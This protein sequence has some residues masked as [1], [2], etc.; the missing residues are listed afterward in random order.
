[1][2]SFF[3]SIVR[4]PKLY[5]N[6]VEDQYMSVFAIA[7]PYT[8]PFKFSHY[9]VSLAHHVIGVWFIRCRLP[10]RKGFVKYIQRGLKS[11]VLQLFEENSLRHLSTHNQD[12]S[13]RGRTGSLNEGRRRRRYVSGKEG[14]RNDGHIPMDEKMSQ[15][16]K[17]LTET[18]LDMMA[19]YSFGNFNALPKRSP[20]AQFLL[21]DG[22]QGMWVVGNKVITVTTSGGGTKSSSSGLC[23]NCLTALQV[24]SQGQE[25][26]SVPGSSSS[27]SPYAVSSS[28]SPGSRQGE[29]RRHRSMASLST[30]SQSQAMKIEVKDGP[31]G[32][33]SRDDSTLPSEPSHDIF[34]H[35]DVAVQTGSS[36]SKEG[37]DPIL[38]ESSQRHADKTQRAF[39]AAQCSCWCTSWAE[40][41]I[42]GASG[43]V[44]WMMRIENEASGYVFDVDPS[45]PD[46]TQLLAPFRCKT[47]DSDS[48]GKIDSGSLCE[49]E[50]ETLHSQ[51]FSAAE[52]ALLQEEHGSPEGQPSHEHSEAREE[53]GSDEDKKMSESPTHLRRISSSPSS[54]GSGQDPDRP[55]LQEAALA[56][57]RRGSHKQQDEEEDASGGKI[58]TCSESSQPQVFPQTTECQQFEF[59]EEVFSAPGTGIGEVKTVSA[60]FGRAKKSELSAKLS[61]EDGKAGHAGKSVAGGDKPT[62]SGSKSTGQT[63]RSRLEF[64]I[65]DETH[66]LLSASTEIKKPTLQRRLSADQMSSKQR[67]E[68]LH[69]TASH[70]RSIRTQPVVNEEES[71][72][73]QDEVP[74]LIT[75][76]RRGHTISVMNAS[77]DIRHS[78]DL[79]SRFKSSAS[80]K[81]GKGGLNPSFVFLQL[82]HCHPLLQSHECPLKVPDTDKFKRSVA[83]LDHIYPYETHKIGVL[84]MGKGQASEERVLLSNEFG[85]PRYT[86]FIHG[87]GQMISL[88]EAE[89][90]KLYLGGLNFPTDG[91]FTV[92][93]QDESLR[94]IFHIATLMPCRK[95]DTRFNNKKSHIGNDFVTIVYN[96]SCED[97]KSGTIS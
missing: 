9:T 10:F 37:L 94:V 17:E 34:G 71:N 90:D 89:K 39:S 81:D 13:D 63:G 2:V 40:V 56:A 84:Y 11:N 82:Y 49:E 12:S 54:L 96:D 95:G 69:L 52:M 19:R 75:M 38:I 68:G 61:H 76:K 87:L 31:H 70:S 1:M 42:R 74:E 97:Y 3:G 33:R 32:R 47:P 36:L 30:R 55:G 7:L 22:Q 92:A 15:F 29:R 20:V 59:D 80:T 60:D 77:S 91:K 67:P 16:H 6:F 5:A 73:Y 18:C 23:D 24:R 65:R 46:I 66:S 21:K 51:H 45:L 62:A 50:Y 25:T 58:T 86:Q 53:R 85:S 27:S 64:P 43:V 72:S 93:W 41:N 8:N 48:I 79:D 88:E 35:D 14:T 44:S 57:E 4:V 26:L 78:D 28:S 83:M